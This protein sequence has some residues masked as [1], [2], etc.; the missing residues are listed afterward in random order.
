[1]RCFLGDSAIFMSMPYHL[2]TYIFMLLAVSPAIAQQLTR[3]KT[4]FSVKTKVK[5]TEQARLVM[6]TCYYELGSQQIVYEVKF[7]VKEVWI[8][9]DSVQLIVR[10]DTLVSTKPAQMRIELSTLHL[11][12][13]QQLANYG[14]KN[15]PFEIESVQKDK[16]LVITTWKPP[17]SIGPKIGKVAT[18]TEDKKLAGVVFYHPKGHIVRKQF[19]KAYTLVQGFP[20]PGEVIDI[21]ND[22]AKETYQQTTYTNIKINEASARNMYTYSPLYVPVGKGT[23]KR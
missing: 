12:L 6:G 5:G 16:N 10:N 3:V 4:D 22:G 23:T 13:T 17:S 15:S 19:F 21:V 7:P 14:L 9:K 11:A 8:F 20:F 2:F 1:M 18:S